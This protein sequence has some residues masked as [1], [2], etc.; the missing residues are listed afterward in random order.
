MPENLTGKRAVRVKTAAV[1]RSRENLT[2]KNTFEE[3]AER[4]PT[5]KRE[6]E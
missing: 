6:W 2:K 4:G 1:V 5:M 3:K